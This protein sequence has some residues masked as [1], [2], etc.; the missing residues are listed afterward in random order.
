MTTFRE[1]PLLRG[2]RAFLTFLI[3]LMAIA[4]AGLAIGAPGILLYGDSFLAELGEQYGS[5]AGRYDVIW[6]F[7]GMILTGLVLAGLAWRFLLL[8]RRIVDSV[9]TGDPFVPENAR[10][11]TAMGWITLAGQVI[12][13]PAIFIGAWLSTVLTDADF[14]FDI[15]LG[16]ILLALVLFILARVFRHGAEMRDD[17][18]GTV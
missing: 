6:A 15:S 8:L 18:E 7:V 16:A 12:V 4:V 1:D 11:L 14:E 9:A 17:L 3:A 2:A 13:I 10:R 5:L